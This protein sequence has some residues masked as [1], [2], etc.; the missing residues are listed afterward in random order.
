MGGGGVYAAGCGTAGGATDCG[1][2]TAG[3]AA[4][5]VPA[6]SFTPETQQLLA[7]ALGTAFFNRQRAFG[8]C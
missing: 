5:A 4:G 6:Y 1:A 7:T 3:A 2:I 8:P